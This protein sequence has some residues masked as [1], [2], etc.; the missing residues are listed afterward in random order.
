MVGLN[1]NFYCKCCDT[2][3][4][5]ES[6]QKEHE[7][8]KKDRKKFAESQAM[9]SS[10]FAHPLPPGVSVIFR[11][12]TCDMFFSGPAQ[13]EEHNQGRKHKA[14]AAKLCIPL[15]QATTEV[16]KVD[17]APCNAAENKKR[18]SESKLAPALE[19][20]PS[21]SKKK[22]KLEK[23]WNSLHPRIQRNVTA[24]AS[25]FL[26]LI[27]LEI[28]EEMLEARRKLNTFSLQRLLED[29]LSLLNM[30]ISSHRL[31]KDYHRKTP[32]EAV[33]KAQLPA[34]GMNSP[35]LQH[36]DICP[37]DVIW[38]SHDMICP[39]AEANKV[40]YYADPRTD[41]DQQSWTDPVTT[42]RYLEGICIHRSRTQL[43]FTVDLEDQP[44]DLYELEQVE[45]VAGQTSNEKGP[46][47]L[48]WGPATLAAVLE[49]GSD[50]GWRID[51]GVSRIAYDRMRD[52]IV[53]ITGP[54]YEG[55][56]AFRE[57]VC[58][59]KARKLD[60]A[61]PAFAYIQATREELEDVPQISA[62]NKTIVE[63]WGEAFSPEGWPYYYNMKTGEVSW[64][65]PHAA[66]VPSD[67]PA[68][69]PLS[70]LLTEQKEED[71]KLDA[72]VNAMEF[73]ESLKHSMED[74]LSQMPLN[75]SQREAIVNCLGSR[76]SLIQGPPGTGKTTTAVYLLVTYFRVFKTG[77]ILATAFSNVAVDQIMHGLTA[78]GIKCVRIGNPT[79]VSEHLRGTTLA[80]L[81][82]RHPDYASVRQQVEEVRALTTQSNS[83]GPGS[84]LTYLQ[85]RKELATRWKRIRRMEEAPA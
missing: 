3:F 40:F 8:G 4:S 25:H 29:G 66:S 12:D 1:P 11:C 43:V 58:R 48:L 65:K 34:I 67:N 75:D 79:K 45:E 14:N 28:Q 19:G 31:H 57:I 77:P 55:H 85:S 24:Y 70:E 50:S 53:R 37:G 47:R 56:S 76:L 33:Y 36:H 10:E 63:D 78:Q 23:Y 60:L 39:V 83:L 46:R 69:N 6:Q 64:L 13:H 59:I 7:L 15:E 42:R 51:K 73:P 41:D 27:E 71:L 49:R 35:E 84:G 16:P 74:A 30:S 32:S 82:E 68:A 72:A 44:K 5:G 38:L 52:A 20:L 18:K 2:F 26:P 61:D 81:T 54:K 22:N 62:Q 21:R 80:E 9:A 17:F